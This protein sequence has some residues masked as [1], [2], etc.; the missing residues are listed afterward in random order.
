MS[1]MVLPIFNAVGAIPIFLF[2]TS[3]SF[4]TWFIFQGYSVETKGKTKTEVL[5]EFNAKGFYQ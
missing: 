5:E 2:I 1:F 3:V 4:I